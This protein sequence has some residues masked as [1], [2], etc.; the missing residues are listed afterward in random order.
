MKGSSLIGLEII[1]S[2]ARAIGKV[3][4]IELDITTWTVTKLVIK[5]GMMKKASVSV[6][7]I[8]KIGDKVILKIPAAKI[9]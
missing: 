9:Q 4:D 3:S 6:H 5:T 2:E 1:D 8:D 7:D